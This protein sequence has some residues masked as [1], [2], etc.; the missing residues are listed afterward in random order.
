MKYCKEC[1][2]PDTRPNTF[3]KDGIC[4][5]CDYFK[6][7]KKVDW[8]QRRE[9]L[10]DLV[11]KYKNPSAQYD[12]IIGVSGGKDSTRQAVWIRDYLKLRPLLVCIQ[13]PPHQVTDV[14]NENLSNLINLGFDVF[15]ICPAPIVWKRLM[16]RDS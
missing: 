14:G 16:K 11:D 3:F 15:Q 8:E 10:F 13:Y 1:L 7:F 6:L 5:A 4:P 2:Q 12:C 9:I